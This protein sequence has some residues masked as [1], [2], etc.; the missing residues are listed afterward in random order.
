M[1]SRWLQMSWRQISNRPSSTTIGL[2]CDTQIWCYR[3]L[4]NNARERSVGRHPLVSITHWGRVTHMC[5]SKLAII[6]SDN[7]LSPGRRQTIIWTN[8]KMLLIQP[9]K[10]NFSEVS[11]KMCRF[12][13]K[14]I[15]LKMSGKWRPFFS[16]LQCVKLV[17]GVCRSKVIIRYGDNKP[18]RKSFQVR[19]W[20]WGHRSSGVNRT[21][22]HTPITQE[23]TRLI[24][25]INTTKNKRILI[26]FQCMYAEENM[27]WVMEE[28][29]N[30][31]MQKIKGNIYQLH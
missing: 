16:R 2:Y 14:K 26:Q 3:H 12:S 9:L 11:M 10:T 7:G 27:E 24:M 6:S 1:S 4:T 23:L 25:L 15:H 30:E 22:H 20:E 17:L 5:V 19:S 29:V 8:A 21:L 13:F 18:V 31:C 28:V